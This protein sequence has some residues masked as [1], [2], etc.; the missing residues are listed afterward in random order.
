MLAADAGVMASATGAVAYIGLR[1]NSEVNWS[2]VYNV[3]GKFCRHI[4]SSI[5]ISIVASI[6]LILLVV[7]SVYSLHRRCH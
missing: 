3:Y 2:K 6:L 1:G 7:P 5:T 4:G